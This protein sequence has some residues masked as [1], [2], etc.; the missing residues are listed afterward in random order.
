L[1][2]SCVIKAEV[3]RK[4]ERESGLRAVL[5]FGH[6][7]GHAIE[8]GQAYAGL[9]HGEAVAVG[10][11]LAARLSTRLGMATDADANQLAN[12][13]E[14]FGLPVAIPA[15]LGPGALLA[16]MK[17]DK[18]ATANGLRFVLWRGPGL[19]E[20]AAGIDENAVRAVLEGRA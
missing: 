2:R 11:V 13:L 20:I 16:R 4:D 17:L 18:K 3:V 5:N 7:F 6:T 9:N 10:M 1:A 12:L 8:A 15:G 14:R 19:A